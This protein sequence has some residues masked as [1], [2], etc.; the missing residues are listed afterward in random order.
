MNIQ[1]LF[2]DDD[3]FEDHPLCPGC[4]G[5]PGHEDGCSECAEVRENER[6]DHRR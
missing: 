4:G 6:L 1:P 5:Y 2:H 3:V